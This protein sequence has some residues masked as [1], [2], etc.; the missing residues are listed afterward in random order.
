M[1]RRGE[2]EE[3]KAAHPSGVLPPAWV[4]IF[5]E[6]KVFNIP[7]SDTQAYKQFGN[8]VVVPVVEAVAQHMKEW[9][10]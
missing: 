2:A 1:R 7:V 9:I 10:K 3:P 4:L 5:W 8:A 6:D